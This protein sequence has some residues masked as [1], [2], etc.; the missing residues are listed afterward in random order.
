[1]E[2]LVTRRER[3]GMRDERQ[4]GVREEKDGLAGH[5]RDAKNIFTREVCRS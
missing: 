2:D 3:E 1:M 4:E 5:E